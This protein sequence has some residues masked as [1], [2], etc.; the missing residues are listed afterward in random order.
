[1]VIAAVVGD[2]LS[3]YPLDVINSRALVVGLEADAMKLRHR[4]DVVGS[5]CEE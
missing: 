2:L 5:L 4:G 1:M 3:H